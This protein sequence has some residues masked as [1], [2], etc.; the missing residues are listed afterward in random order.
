MLEWITAV[1]T[2]LAA[3][4]PF[5]LF[6]LERSD[7]KSAEAERDALVKVEFGREWNHGHGI[8]ERR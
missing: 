1:G 8:A 6:L 7:R 5:V 2:L 3:L 4:V